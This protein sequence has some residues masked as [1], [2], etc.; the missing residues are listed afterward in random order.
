MGITAR[1]A[2]ESVK[3]HFRHLGLDVQNEDFT[4]V[5]IGDMSGDVFGNGMLL[6]RH[7]RLL[8]AFDHRHVFVDPNPDAERSW[9]ERERL[10]NLAGS[11]WADY[12]SDLISE[13][14]GVFSRTSKAIEVTPQMAE[15]LGLDATDG[16]LTPP[17][18]MSAILRAPVDLLWNGG[19]GTYV[20]A[21]SET[22]E[23]AADRANDIL[24]VSASQL[25]C[26]VIG[27][28][29]NLGLTQRSRIEFARAGGMVNNDAIDNSAGVDC[30]DH[31]VNL[32][33]LL[34]QVVRD[35]DLTTKQRNEL[36]ADMTEDVGAL[37]LADNR[38]QN[39]AL[40][41]ART[42][43]PGMVDVHI[44]HLARLEQVGGLDRE[45][46]FLPSDEE[47]HL[48]ERARRRPHPAGAGRAAGVH[49]DQPRRGA[50]RLGPA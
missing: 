29:G 5:G 40:A 1:G 39:V 13:G 4:V 26:R 28:G 43:A 46:E 44:R 23:D 37:V 8:A 15:A 22:N 10:Y 47:L 35:G 48:E 42:Q 32:K 19:I 12:D 31:E 41:A 45:L 36:L 14:G 18:L 21:S 49:E 11:S 16:V 38:A 20:K 27:E 9:Q 34:D 3:F 30:S 24:R 17:Q 2:W 6:S 7:I 50:A 25:R 33:I